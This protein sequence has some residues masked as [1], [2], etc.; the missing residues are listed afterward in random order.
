L[1]EEFLYAISGFG[2]RKIFGGDAME[3]GVCQVVNLRF[4]KTGFL[5]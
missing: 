1:S 3:S 2:S 5:Q 4:F